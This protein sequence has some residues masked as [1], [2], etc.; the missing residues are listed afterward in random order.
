MDISYQISRQ[1]IILVGDVAVGKT[2]IVNSLIGQQF[3]DDYEPSIGIDF[4]SKTIRFKERQLKLQIW[5]SAGQEKFR[6]LIPNYLRGAV[7]IF[8]IYDVTCRQTF[9]NLQSWIDFVNNV[10]NTSIVI[11]GNKI[12]LEN[13]RVVST[14]E[15]Q[16]FADSKKMDFFE[17]SAKEETNLQYMLFNSIAPLS[18]FENLT[19]EK[20]TKEQIVEC[21]ENENA[22]GLKSEVKD[23]SKFGFS[24]KMS[25]MNFIDTDTSK[26]NVYVPRDKDNSLIE[27]EKKEEKSKGCCK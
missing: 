25:K 3:S 1:K 21:L 4:F 18:V 22:E 7:L 10:E 20:L 23:L 12:D 9:D 13:E 16:A 11:V 17:V 27:L 26:Q 5:D 2:S 24:A 15:G 19:R 6:S 14:E 8:L